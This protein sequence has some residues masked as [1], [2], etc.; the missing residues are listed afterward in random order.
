MFALIVYP[1]ARAQPQSST[2]PRG[3]PSQWSTH[4]RAMTMAK[5][6]YTPAIGGTGRGLAATNVQPT[7]LHPRCMGRQANPSVPI[8]SL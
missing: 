7:E 8:L 2:I 1:R 5:G 3:T 6:G 4:S